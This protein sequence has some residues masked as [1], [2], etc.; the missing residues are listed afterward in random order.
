MAKKSDKEHK[1]STPVTV[2]KAMA[3]N[4]EASAFF[5]RIANIIEQARRL[6]GRTADLTLCVSYFEIGRLIVEKEQ[7][8]KARA[9]Y[10]KGLIKELSSFLNG[11]FKKG[12]SESTLKY[13]RQFYLTYSKLIR[14]TFFGEL[15]NS[16]EEQKQTAQ[17]TVSSGNLGVSIRQTLSSELES[18]LPTWRAAF[19]L[20]WSHYLI[21]IRINNKD[22]R[23]FM[24]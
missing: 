18:N 8:G 10:G 20:S 22:E 12:F 4:T 3:D 19:K 2:N 6:V 15:Q 1:P 7:D 14:Q 24:R 13:A 5:D 9:E 17:S 16:G 21:L 23:R 11:R